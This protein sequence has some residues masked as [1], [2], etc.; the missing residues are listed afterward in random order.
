MAGDEAAL[1]YRSDVGR[2]FDVVGEVS[3]PMVGLDANLAGDER[4]ARASSIAKDKITDI[5]EALDKKL[6]EIWPEEKRSKEKNVI[7]MIRMATPGGGELREVDGG[8]V[9]TYHAQVAGPNALLEL[10]PLARD[11]VSRSLALEFGIHAEA[12]TL[13]WSPAAQTANSYPLYADMF[14]DGLDVYI[15]VGGDHLT[16]RH[17]LDEAKAI[18]TELTTSLGLRSPV[19]RFE[20]LKIDSR[21]LKGSMTVAGK[22]VEIRASLVWADMA[23]ADKL[24]TLLDAFRDHAKTADVVIYR[25]HAGTQLDYSG[26]VAHY[27]PRVSIPATE[28][29][30]LDLP[31]K[32][33]LFFFDGCETYTGYADQ[34]YEHPKKDEKN[35]DVITSVSYA[36]ALYR[37]EGVRSFLHSVI[38]KTGE[39]WIPRSWDDVISS[40]NKNQLGPWTSIY[41]V[42]GLEDNP[43]VSMLADTS[44]IGHACTYHSDCRGDDSLCVAMPSG[45]SCGAAC[46]D[47]SGCPTG[48]KCIAV[49]SQRFGTTRQCVPAN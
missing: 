18:Y 10:L 9:F 16:P 47:D 11:G 32:Y 45:K 43:R 1:N 14:E 41:G 6:F 30:N 24:D 26:V 33:Q 20:D 19:G 4:T 44:W 2:E 7:A 34:I 25:G 27:N 40:L 37:G 8:Y 17:D 46:T 48:D 28:F 36:S 12:L 31:S 42:H 13:N 35:A 49:T 22:A 38:D 29:R 39:K 3:V 15:H 21:P 5:T 23:P